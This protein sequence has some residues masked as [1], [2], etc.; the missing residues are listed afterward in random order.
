MAEIASTWTR[1]APETF[2]GAEDAQ[3]QQRAGRDRLPR[4]ERGE[5]GAGHSGVPDRVRRAPAVAPGL[6]DRVH[7]EHQAGGDQ[8]RAQ[9]VGS[10]AQP[11]PVVG[12][13]HPGGQDHGRG[14]DR[15]VDEEDPVPAE[16]LG[17]DPPEDLADGGACRA[18]ETERTDRRAPLARLREQRDDHAQAHRRGRR[19]ADALGEPRGDQHLLAGG[20]PAQQRRGGEQGQAGDERAL[21]AGQVAEPAGQQQQAAEGDQV[22]VD[23][24]GQ[25]GGR[26]AEAAL[27]HRQR[28]GHDAAV[29]DDHQHCRAEHREGQPARAGSGRCR[30]GHGVI[31]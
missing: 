25:I 2:A 7:A 10:R 23:D 18:D 20:D 12:L 31:S 21:A 6:H 9:G 17:E 15:Q 8:Q 4:D 30:L 14:A 16:S 28:H 24:P 1:L 5:Q 19:P 27:D 26:E 3:R 22:G 11:G 13:E 29:E